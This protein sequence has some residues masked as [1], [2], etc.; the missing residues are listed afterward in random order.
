MQINNTNIETRLTND[1]NLLHN[2]VAEGLQIANIISDEIYNLA[3]RPYLPSETKRKKDNDERFF[4]LCELADENEII[5]KRV[6]AYYRVLKEDDVQKKELADKAFFIENQKSIVQFQEYLNYQIKLQEMIGFINKFKLLLVE[7]EKRY[8]TLAQA[9]TDCFRGLKDP[10]DPKLTVPGLPEGIVIKYNDILDYVANN[11]SKKIA[12]GEVNAK[13]L[14]SEIIKS[15]EEYLNNEPQFVTLS[16]DM[17]KKVSNEAI[18]WIKD[19][20]N[21]NPDIENVMREAKREAIGIDTQIH[22]EANFIKEFAEKYLAPKSFNELISSQLNEKA[23]NMF[24]KPQ[25]IPILPKEKDEKDEDLLSSLD[26]DDDLDIDID[27]KKEVKLNDADEEKNQ[28]NDERP[29]FGR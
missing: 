11:V 24:I 10:S 12:N 23:S 16:E 15:S 29:R 6:L 26:E 2:N 4:L 28:N 22:V 18:Q 14:D 17:Q 7:K 21:A 13:D 5:I 8:A 25:R 19:R 20:R 1:L 3:H 9:V 27:D